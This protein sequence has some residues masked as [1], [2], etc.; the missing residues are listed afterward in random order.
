MGSCQDNKC[1]DTKVVVRCV[2]RRLV[3]SMRSFW[4]KWYTW[5]VDVIYEEITDFKGPEQRSITTKSVDWIRRHRQRRKFCNEGLKD[6]SFLATAVW[7][8]QTWIPLRQIPIPGIWAGSCEDGSREQAPQPTPFGQGKRHSRFTSRLIYDL[9][10][11]LVSAATTTCV[12]SIWDFVGVS[13]A[14]FLSR[15]NRC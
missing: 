13:F 9:P 8:T 7:E 12:W 15:S 1:M 14:C 3:Q 4:T 6:R 2:V 5:V 10:E 11:F